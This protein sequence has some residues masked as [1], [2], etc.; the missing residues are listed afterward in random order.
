MSLKCLHALP[1]LHT[2]HSTFTEAISL[3][4]DGTIPNRHRNKRNVSGIH[5]NR[6]T[7]FSNTIH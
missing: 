2:G 6:G 5:L 7:C 1:P 4:Q 3:L